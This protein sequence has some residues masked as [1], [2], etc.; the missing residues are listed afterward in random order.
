MSTALDQ[1][2]NRKQTFEGELERIEDRVSCILFV[3]VACLSLW[4]V[5][6]LSSIFPF[7]GACQSRPAV[8][9]AV[10][11]YELET[12]YLSA[13]HSQCGTVLKVLE[14]EDGSTCPHSDFRP[15]N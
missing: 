7:H 15:D 1:L 3:A 4:V 12:A 11:L 9:H 8:P 6:R 13:E 5:C 2:I 10:Q 14:C